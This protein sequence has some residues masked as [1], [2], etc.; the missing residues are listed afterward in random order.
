MDPIYT[1]KYEERHKDEDVERNRLREGLNKEGGKEGG[2][3]E[4]GEGMN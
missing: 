3:N 4:G 1:L 2:P